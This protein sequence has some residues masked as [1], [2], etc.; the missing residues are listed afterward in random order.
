MRLQISPPD[1]FLYQSVPRPISVLR[2]GPA[3]KKRMT[4]LARGGA[5]TYFN[6]GFSDFLERLVN[7]RL[8]PL[9][10][11]ALAQRRT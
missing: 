9:F 4:E 10:S 6:T 2:S 8:A 11:A 5:P 3:L 1:C 7:C